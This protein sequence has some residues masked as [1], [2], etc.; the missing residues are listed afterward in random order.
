[1]Q[2]N[3][4]KMAPGIPMP[5]ESPL[6]QDDKRCPICWVRGE[7]MKYCT[8]APNGP[9]KAD[10]TS[11][12]LE[13]SIALGL[14]NSD[15][16]GPAILALARLLEQLQGGGTLVLT[17]PDPLAPKGMKAPKLG[18]SMESAT[19]TRF[20][21]AYGDTFAEIFQQLLDGWSKAPESTEEAPES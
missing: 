1:M 3:Q 2:S 4:P 11:F 5:D 17:G 10:A 6:K 20:A 14:D 21:D 19:A 12:K 15:H 18:A 13:L 8:R 7:H 16:A 9:L